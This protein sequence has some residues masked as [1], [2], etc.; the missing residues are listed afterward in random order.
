M[1]LRDF[2]RLLP[3]HFLRR[4]KLQRVGLL[5]GV[6][7]W[8]VAVWLGWGVPSAMAGLTDDRYDGNI[9]ALY[10]GNGSLVPPRTTLEQSIKQGRPALLVIYVDDSS[11]CKRYASTISQLQGPYGWAASIVPIMAD[12]IPVK[13]RY[14]PTEPG[15]YFKNAVPQTVVLNGQGQVVLNEIGVLSYEQIDDALREVF[16]LLPR[17]ESVELRRRSINEVN[18][19]LVRE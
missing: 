11:D 18:S 4:V 7:L 2:I 13:D 15:Y 8:G 14:E 5:L 17:E 16:D 12:S 1:L 6:M 3:G 19:E 10:A 9:F